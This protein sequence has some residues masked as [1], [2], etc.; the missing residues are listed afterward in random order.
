M[1]FNL[2]F[3]SLSSRLLSWPAARGVDSRIFLT[4]PRFR[5]GIPITLGTR[6]T[7]KSANGTSVID[8]YPDYSWHQNPAQDCNN[9]IVSVF[10]VA[11]RQNLFCIKFNSINRPR[12]GLQIDACQRLWVVDTGKIGL[13]ESQQVCAP[14]ILVFNLITNQLLHRY[15]IPRNQYTDKSLFITP[16]SAEITAKVN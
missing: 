10:R 13:A 11:V 9:K 4:F 14:K 1:E 3:A 8:A 15:T 16:V 12:F 7:T 2:I 6:S 5:A